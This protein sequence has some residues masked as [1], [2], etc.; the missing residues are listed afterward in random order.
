M[1]RLVRATGIIFVM[2]LIRPQN[3]SALSNIL[4]KYGGKDP[5]LLNDFEN[6]LRAAYTLTEVKEQLSE[7]KSISFDA[8]LISDRHF[9]VTIESKR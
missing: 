4:N 6:S 8:K 3:E 1:I 2:D 7:F 5:I 9:F